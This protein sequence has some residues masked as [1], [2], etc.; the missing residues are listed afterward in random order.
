MTQEPQHH[1]IRPIES[2]GPNDFVGSGVM[3]A[4]GLIILVG[5]VSVDCVTKEVS[6]TLRFVGVAVVGS[7]LGPR[8]S[9]IPS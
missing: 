7:V 6:D 4:S 3:L 2:Q 8:V 5:V 9:E 1:G